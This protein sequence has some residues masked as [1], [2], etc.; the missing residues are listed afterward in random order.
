[1]LDLKYSLFFDNHTMK[2]CPDVGANFDAKKFVAEVKSCGVDFLTFHARCN[3]GFAYYNTD[4]G[5]RHPSLKRDLFGELAE[6]CHQNGIRLNAYI[7]G[8]ISHEEGLLHRD[9]TR[10]TPDGK[11]FAL[12]ANKDNVGFVAMCPSNAGY[13]EHVVKMVQ[14]ILERYPVSGFFF[15]CMNPKPCICPGCMSAIKQEG[16]DW[17]SW[18]ELFAFSGRVH[19]AMARKLTAAIRELK[20]DAILFFNGFTPLIQQ[21]ISDYLDVECLPTGGWGYDN[22]A[23]CTRYMRNFGKPTLHM[24]GRFHTSWGDFGGIRTSASLEYDCFHAL[25]NGLWPNIGSHFHPRGDINAAEFQLARKVYSA[26]QKYD[27]WY[28]G[29]KPQTDIAVFY[30]PHWERMMAYPAIDGAT[31]ML[32]ELKCQFDVIS[33]WKKIANYKLLILPDETT[34]DVETADLLRRFVMGGGKII[35]SGHSG[36]NEQ[37]NA[38]AIPEWGMEYRGEDPS[39]PAYLQLDYAFFKN[40][41]PMPLATYSKGLLVKNLDG[42][43]T[44]ANVIAPYYNEGFDGTS[45]YGYTP[46]DRS[47]E[48]PAIV[49]KHSIAYFA[50]PVF[51]SYYEKAFPYTKY[52]VRDVLSKLLPEPLLRT[53]NMPSFGRATVTSQPSRRMVHL[54]AYVPEMRGKGC[55]MIEEPCTVTEAKIELKLDG[56]PPK[57]VTLAPECKTLPFEV[58]EGY[59]RVDVPAFKGYAMV[60]FE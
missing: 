58:K 23:V 38:F 52:I 11:S 12:N 59:V 26:A 31:R 50:H 35:A 1:M 49:L 32:A 57:K 39:N 53:E 14:E 3:Q 37:G 24:T 43:G 42:Q 6:E 41:P 36:L 56:P 34:I 60:V 55:E 48:N 16:V 20:P 28:D 51:S 18:K 5:I 47:T 25:A 22:L 9:W 44:L 8:G 54:L 29:A 46:P 33:D 19:L 7:N 27:A 15:D 21:E 45:V 2:A 40:L 13:V 30:M 10:I 4:I 17:N